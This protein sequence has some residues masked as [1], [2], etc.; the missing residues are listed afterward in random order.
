MNAVARDRLV[1]DAPIRTFH[2]LFASAFAVAWLTGDA[3]DWRAL[4]VALGYCLAGLLGWRLVYGLVG[5]QPARLGA[6]GRRFASL[7]RWLASLAQQRRGL[8]RPQP[9]DAPQRAKLSASQ[10][11]TL[12]MAVLPMILMAGL[13]FLALSGLA[14]YQDW[15]GLGHLTEELHEGLALALGLLALAH[16]LWVAGLSLLRGRNLA[17]VMVSGRVAGPGPDLVRHERRRWALLLAVSALMAT[18]MLWRE[19]ARHP[20]ARAAAERSDAADTDDDD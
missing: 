8:E 1:T 17:A 14:T 5:P 15:G 7:L 11:A 2:L 18:A 4:H 16:P 19:E 12:L 3:D 13:P 10:A 6:M 9:L 20:P